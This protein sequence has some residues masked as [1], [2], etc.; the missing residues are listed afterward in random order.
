MQNPTPTL[1]WT[2]LPPP[3]TSHFGED[4]NWDWSTTTQ[5]NLLQDTT[6]I[7]EDKKNVPRHCHKDHN[8]E[9]T[10]TTI[11][12]TR[13]IPLY[14][15]QKKDTS[16]TATP[17]NRP[18]TSVDE[19]ISILVH[20]RN[21]TNDIRGA[22]VA[23]SQRAVTTPTYSPTKRTGHDSYSLPTTIT[24]HRDRGGPNH[25]KPV[26]VPL[27]SPISHPRPPVPPLPVPALSTL[28]IRDYDDQ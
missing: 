26:H 7:L 18:S 20:L 15:D 21:P 4:C 12:K 2:N 24:L 6:I 8:F 13:R 28:K 27:H 10:G 14:S 5:N 16:F 11:L 25:H 19:L 22:I 1:D 3:A 23:Q 17:W 9:R